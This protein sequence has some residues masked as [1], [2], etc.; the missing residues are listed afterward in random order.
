MNRSVTSINYNCIGVSSKI[1]SFFQKQVNIDGLDIIT[2]GDR[3]WITDADNNVY[4][5]LGFDLDLILKPDYKYFCPSIS[6]NQ[7][8]HKFNFRKQILLKKFPDKVTSDM[9]EKE[10]TDI[11]GFYRIWDCGLFRYRLKR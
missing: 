3:N 8:L 2:F 1:L 5:K 11:L 4:T 7:R 10:M 9:S 6:R